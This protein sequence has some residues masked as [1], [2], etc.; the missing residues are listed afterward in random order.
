MDMAR[1]EKMPIWV[2]RRLAIWALAVDGRS[3]VAD[4]IAQVAQDRDAAMDWMNELDEI[5]RLG[6]FAGQQWFRKL[7]GWPDQ[8]EI[9]RGDHRLVGFW[10]GDDLILCLH[11]LKRKQSTDRRD[12][13]RVARL[14]KEW[15]RQHGKAMDA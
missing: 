3:E 7:V 9:R 8:W 4:F 13:E 14:A 15:V 5:G 11:R 2:K 12:L 10:I 6:H 1:L